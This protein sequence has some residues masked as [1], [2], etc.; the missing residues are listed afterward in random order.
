MAIKII[1]DSSSDLKPE[2]IKDYNIEV[3]PIF[4]YIDDEEF[5]DEITITSSE[6]A[7]AMIDGKRVKTAQVPMYKYQKYFDTLEPGDTLLCVPIASGISSNYEMVFQTARMAKEENPDLDIRVIDAKITS[8][9]LGITL[10]KAGEMIN[11]NATADEVE[12]FIIE[13]GEYMK[14]IFTVSSLKWLLEGGRVSKTAAKMGT[15]LDIMPILHIVEG[16]LIPFDKARG[17]KNRFNKMMKYI[18]NNA[19]SLENQIVGISHVNNADEA[20]KIADYLKENMN[21][22]KVVI[23]QIGA[24]I[25]CHTGPGLICVSFKGD[26]KEAVIK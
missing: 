22:K 11:N 6:I 24:V 12:Q 23:K 18:E 20:K 7:Q 16:K 1:T 4:A 5:L 2:M 10:I 8:L 13:E 9:G 25:A 14:H 19:N 3:I 17:Q 26:N 15:L 21:A